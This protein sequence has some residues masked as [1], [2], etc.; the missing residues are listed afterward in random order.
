[1]VNDGKSVDVK[2][3][4]GSGFGEVVVEIGRRDIRLNNKQRYQFNTALH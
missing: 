2:R 1:L 4:D 3:G